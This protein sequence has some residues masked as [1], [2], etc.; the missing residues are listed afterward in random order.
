MTGALNSN[1]DYAAVLAALRPRGAVW[2]QDPSSVQEQV[3]AALAPTAERV[4]AAAQALLVDS[5]P[6][7]AVGLLPEWE[8]SLGLTQNDEGQPLD[9]RQG[10]VVAALTAVG[11][12]S[13]R[14]MIDAAA[15]LGATITIQ[16]HAPFRCGFNGC[17]DPIGGE[18]W[19]FAWSIHILENTGSL[20]SGEL[21]ADIQAIAPAE[22]AV[23]LA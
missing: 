15:A 18:A 2:P 23:F 3:L 6:A 16:T 4:D 14:V 13:Q 17:G 5:F 1:A 11:G 22:T 20:S 21:L 7:T 10:N 19:C 12:Q 8:A 9:I